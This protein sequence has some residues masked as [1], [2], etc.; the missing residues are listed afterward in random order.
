MNTMLFFRKQMFIVSVLALLLTPACRRELLDQAPDEQISDATA[1]D[2]PDRIEKLRFGL[3]DALKAP[4]MYGSRFM[5]YSDI[6]GEEFLNEGMQTGNGLQVWNH[7]LDAFFPEV[8]E[9]W[10]AGYA[11]INGCNIFID[12]IQ[13][14]KAV[15]HNDQLAIQYEAEAKFIRGLTYYCLLTLYARPYP[16]GNGAKPGLIL[17]LLPEPGSSNKNQSRTTVAAVYDQI[18]EDLDFAR[19]NLPLNRGND[20]GNTTLAHRNTAIALKTRVLLTMGR[21]QDLITEASTIVSATAPFVATGQGVPN[22]L[23]DDILRV[24]SSPY[25]TLENIFSLPNTA[26]DPLYLQRAAASYYNP[27]PNGLGDYSL[28]PNGILMDAAFAATDDRR[29]FV[30]DN[31]ENNKPYLIKYPTGTPHTDYVPV[32]RYA[33]VLLN[34]S[35]AHARTAGL[36]QRAVDLLNAVRGRSNPAGVYALSDFASADALIAAILKERRIELMGEGFRSNDCTRLLLPIPG[37]GNIATIQPNDTRY[38]WPIPSN[39]LDTNDFCEQNP[40]Y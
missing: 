7:S 24:F 26:A 19:D 20:Y 18:L 13:K 25:T 8:T 3:Y 15:L 2:T 6:R 38:I 33:E 4:S 21:Y 16:D 5:V 9:V 29:Q 40:G 34:L 32:I 30:F 11:I 14:N 28:N 39:E 37:K 17:R 35:E 22:A 23:Q 12:G 27:P 10:T 1:F 36:S 31:P